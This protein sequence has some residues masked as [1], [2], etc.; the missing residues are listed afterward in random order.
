MPPAA[1]GSTS[2]PGVSFRPDL[3]PSRFRPLKLKSEPLSFF[4]SSTGTPPQSKGLDQIRYRDAR[5]CPSLGQFCTFADL[6][7]RSPTA[8]PTAGQ[9]LRGLH[10]IECEDLVQVGRPRVS[11]AGFRHCWPPELGWVS[12]P[13]IAVAPASGFSTQ[14]ISLDHLQASCPLACKS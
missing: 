9:H 7:H 10:G 13:A 3:S 6:R 4:L 8:L 11:S 12:S 14:V 2:L 5:A 1:C